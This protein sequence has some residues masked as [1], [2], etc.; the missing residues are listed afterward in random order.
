[1][2]IRLG[3]VHL[4]FT[5]VRKSP[6]RSEVWHPELVRWLEW[7]REQTT[8]E[9]RL[10]GEAIALCWNPRALNLAREWTPDPLE[11]AWREAAR[12]QGFSVAFQEGTRHATLTAL[13]DVLPERVLRAYSR[14]RDARSLDR[15]SKPTPRAA[16][17]R[18]IV[19][20]ENP[21]ELP[22]ISPTAEIEP[23]K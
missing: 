13:G 7:R 3:E 5:P 8:P 14:H 6:G 21:R 1:V 22:H 18:R 20:A 10:R 2:S 9:Q 11:R 15:Y 19:G 23:R 17:L 12:S 4:R 16:E